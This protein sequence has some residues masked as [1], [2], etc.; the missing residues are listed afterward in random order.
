MSDSVRTRYA[1]SPT[2]RLHIGGARTALFNYLFAKAHGGTFVLRIED[3]DRERSRPE[4]ERDISESLTWLGI[5]PD[6][7]P[8]RGGPFGPYRQSERRARYEEALR[9]LT[10]ENAVY[11]C[12]CDDERLEAL[13]EERL[14]RGERPG[15]DGRCRRLDEGE[16]ERLIAAGVPHAWRFALPR[17]RIAFVDAIRGFTEIDLRSL[18]DFVVFRRD[19]TPSYHLA[20]VVDDIEMKIT[21]VL[22]GEDHLANTGMH[23]ALYRALGATPPVFAH[24]PLIVAR[25]GAKLSKREGD[26]AISDLRER[27]ILP[28][29]IVEYLAHLGFSPEGSLLTLRE[30][31][32][33]FD[34]A[35]VGKSPSIFEYEQLVEFNRRWLTSMSGEEI[36]ERLEPAGAPRSGAPAAWLALWKDN[37]ATLLDLASF[38]ALYREIAPEAAL[39]A[40]ALLAP[41]QRAAFHSC[42]ESALSEAAE[43]FD[44]DRFIGKCM[45]AGISRG[46]AMKAVRVALTGLSSGPSLRGLIA[47]LPAETVR[48]RLTGLATVCA[49]QSGERERADESR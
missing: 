47:A 18:S 1:P 22:R 36:A 9:A 31:A 4:F 11:P 21:H 8:D 35:R 24:L 48:E 29:A 30:L 12:F 38:A 7:S 17:E 28:E 42:L 15:Y 39:E 10:A 3:T 2:G 41:A 45:D 43:Q 27:G 6:E 34:L 26:T 20:V 23:L 13:R 32:A 46:A 49:Q 40:C 44:L 37:A 33:Q 25:D 14:A 19:G 5:V 16:R